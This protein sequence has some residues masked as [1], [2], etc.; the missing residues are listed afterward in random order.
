MRK[1]LQLG[2]GSAL[3]EPHSGAAAPASVL[4]SCNDRQEPCLLTIT[5]HTTG[6][7]AVH[8]QSVSAS[9]VDAEEDC[10][11]WQHEDHVVARSLRLRLNLCTIHN[12]LCRY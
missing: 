6:V 1:V 11:L 2:E 8:Q 10:I 12:A 4:K 7:N 5:H 3:G 9:V